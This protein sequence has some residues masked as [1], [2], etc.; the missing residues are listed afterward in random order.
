MSSRKR[1]LILLYRAILHDEKE[2]PDAFAFKPERWLK[3]DGSLNP[4]V[5]DPT[6]AF[7]FG[8][9]YASLSCSLALTMP[10]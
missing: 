2:Y 7:G 6:V 9:R 4:S 10:F 3:P 8:R 1:E 5:R